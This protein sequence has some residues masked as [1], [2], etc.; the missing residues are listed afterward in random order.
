[1]HGFVLGNF[2]Q[3]CQDA[4]DAMR[5]IALHGRLVLIRPFKTWE[6]FAPKGLWRH[7]NAL[8]GLKSLVKPIRAL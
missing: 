3:G 7:Y 5:T 2:T 8:E 4:P 1:M 6:A